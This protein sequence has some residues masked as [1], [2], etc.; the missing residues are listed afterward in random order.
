[1]SFPPARE[2]ALHVALAVSAMSVAAQA[3]DSSPV[4]VQLDS[5]MKLESGRAQPAN[6]AAS[7]VTADQIEGNP[8][9]EL[10]LVGNAEIRRGGS[11]LRAD[12]IT[13]VQ[14]TD[15]VIATGNARISG[16]GASFS[17]PSMRFRITSREG[18]M[19]DAEWEYAPRNLRGCA[20]NIRFVSGVFYFSLSSFIKRL[21]NG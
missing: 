14:E 20:R 2:I 11:V 13:Y 3:A 15:E 16:Q 18:S 12:R 6:D 4:R 10:H 8:E 9:D 5:V 17:G 19:E 21:I 7:F 1:M